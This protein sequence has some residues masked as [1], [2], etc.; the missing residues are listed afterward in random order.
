MSLDKYLEVIQADESIFPMDQFATKSSPIDSSQ[1]A[2]I[3]SS[4]KRKHKI[5][6]IF[7]ENAVSHNSY[8]RRIMVD[9]DR[10]IHEYSQGWTQDEPY[11]PPFPEAK[12]ALETLKDLGF[13]VIIFTTRVS[14]TNA[15]DM[16]GDVAYQRKLLKDY[17][18]KYQLPYDFITAEK[19]AAEF[20]ID[21]HAVRIENGDWTSVLNFVK[22][23]MGII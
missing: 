22:S 11:D 21:D 10:T 7:P 17:F 1:V 8:K 3:D 13:E 5:K 14:E 18:E 23:K 19:I 6:N 12:H 16:G 20:Y 4:K 15:R 9:F 2:P